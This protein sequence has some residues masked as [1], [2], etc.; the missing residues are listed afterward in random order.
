MHNLISVVSRR[1]VGLAASAV[2]AAGMVGGVLLT[3][4]TAF[5][6]TA[7]TTTAITSVTQTAGGSG[8]TLHV[9]VTVTPTSSATAWPTGTMRVSDGVGGG[10]NLALSQDGLG[11]TAGTGNCYIPNLGAGTYTLQASYPGD[12]N[13]EGSSG[14][15]SVTVA[16]WKNGHPGGPSGP[17]GFSRLSTSLHCSS[18]VRSG[19]RGTCTLDVTNAG[20]GTVQDVTG[21]I[22][23]PSQLKADFCGHGWSWGWFNSWG[24]TISGNGASEN[25]GSLRPGQSGSVTVTFTAQST[26]WLWGWGRQFREWVRVTGSAQSQG[27]WNNSSWF[28]GNGS[29]SSASVEILP[30]R[31]WW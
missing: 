31:F 27:Y 13:F 16:G 30:P 17:S 2:L 20:S 12:S 10:C 9:F 28:G 25:L 6:A 4:G 14:T 18:P 24:C 11:S 8:T 22:D 29:Y 3:P 21:Q 19:A 15:D 23:L 5:A 1:R 26:R 7:N